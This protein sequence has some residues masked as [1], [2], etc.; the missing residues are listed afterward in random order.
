MK[1]HTPYECG[2]RVEF[3]SVHEGGGLGSRKAAPRLVTFDQA[4]QAPRE[5][6]RVYDGTSRGQATA[7]FLNEVDSLAHKDA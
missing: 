4:C 7:V 5:V 3:L 6:A 1:A 2:V